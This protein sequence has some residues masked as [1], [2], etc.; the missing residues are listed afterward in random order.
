MRWFW[1]NACVTLQSLSHVTR[2]MDALALSP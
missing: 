1:L 2:V